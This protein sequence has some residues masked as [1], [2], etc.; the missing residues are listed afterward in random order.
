MAP[1][2]QSPLGASLFGS[3]VLHCTV[4]TKTRCRRRS[5]NTFTPWGVVPLH[6]RNPSLEAPVWQ[7]LRRGLSYEETRSRSETAGFLS[8]RGTLIAASNEG[9]LGG[10]AILACRHGT[11]L[12]I[13]IR[14]FPGQLTRARGYSGHSL[15][16]LG[17]S[18]VGAY[19]V[20]NPRMG[21]RM[22]SIHGCTPTPHP[23]P[24]KSVVAQRGASASRQ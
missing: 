23:R 18:L 8:A 3:R 11:Q 6:A 21:G 7:P 5:C 1:R 20:L 2:G 16:S 24:F 13:V 10:V 15:V 9:T 19:H 17:F 14:V 4:M 22:V 12:P